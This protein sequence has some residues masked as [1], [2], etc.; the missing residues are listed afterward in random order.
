M[1]DYSNS[2]LIRVKAEVE[3]SIFL[4]LLKEAHCFWLTAIFSD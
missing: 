3:L 2:E 4:L 1:S